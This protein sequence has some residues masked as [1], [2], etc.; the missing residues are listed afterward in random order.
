M[1]ENKNENNVVATGKE[2][3]NVPGFDE[4]KNN[5][6]FD[7]SKYSRNLN[8]FEIITQSENRLINIGSEI[9]NK[10]SVQTDLKEKENEINKDEIKD[11]SQ[12]N[13]KGIFSRGIDWISNAFK[14]FSLLWKSEELID[15]YD[16]NGN[17]V[18]KPK[19][20]IPLKSKEKTE[21]QISKNI[22][23]DIKSD[24]LNYA[25]DN[26]NYGALFN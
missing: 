19:N 6:N 18:K 3:E 21:D 11:I 5:K 26:I 10:E 22:S 8:N 7:V 12:E 1:K 25:H 2:N 14:E 20:K 24:T 23:D 15:A 4:N 17:L 13:K 9:E 16:A